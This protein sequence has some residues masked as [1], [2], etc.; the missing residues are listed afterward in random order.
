MTVFRNFDA[1]DIV[2]A[3][4]SEVTLG[5]WTGD[6]GSLTTFFT[7]S[8]QT[9]ST[10]GKYEWDVYQAD[11]AG[12]TAEIQFAI[13][14]GNISGSGDE[15]LANNDNALLTTEA[16]Y[17]QFRNILLEPTDTLFT[18]GTDTAGT[19]F[20]SDDIWVIS[21][22]RQR[23]KEKLD[24]G[25]WILTLHSNSGSTAAAVVS[26]TQTFIDNSG[27]TLGPTYG[28]SGRVFDVVSGSLTGVSGST[29]V[30][31]AS[32]SGGFG[33]FYPD[34]GIIVLNPN[35]MGVAGAVDFPALGTTA[36]LQNQI[37]L[38]HAIE[39][40]SDF[41]AR[42]AETVTSTHYFVRLKNQAFNYSNNPTFFNQTTG[43]VSNTDFISDPQVYATTIGL[44]ND[45]NELVAVAKV[46][47]PVRKSFDREALIR[48][49]LDY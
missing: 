9:G 47:R 14:Y 4:P 1:D 32:V 21:I 34:L 6:T 38:L 46:S 29:V 33:K 45:N 41:Q 40:G 31:S 37:K 26:G 25:N 22:R 8:T 15:L 27:Q 19:A 13:A 20:N 48:V 28:T 23:L 10:A 7:S 36:H 5:L 18:F 35:A 16:I 42:S 24:P 30:S 12:A 43:A 2:Q 11:P 44:Y 3:N 17:K 49:R 39:S